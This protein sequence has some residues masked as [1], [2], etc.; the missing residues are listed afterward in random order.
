MRRSTCD[1]RPSGPLM[2]TFSYPNTLPPV[3]CP[4]RPLSN[5]P[6]LFGRHF[7]GTCDLPSDGL[8]VLGDVLLVAPPRVDSREHGYTLV[9]RALPLRVWPVNLA[10][11]ALL[12]ARFMH[13]REQ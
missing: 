11:A 8:G 13:A 12:C 5:M 7:T 3:T 2:T 9:Q 1:L 4:P 6:S 10:R